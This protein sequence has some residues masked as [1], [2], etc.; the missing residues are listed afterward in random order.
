MNIIQ[1]I[2]RNGT[3]LVEMVSKMLDTKKNI[4]MTTTNNLT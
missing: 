2:I 1:I 3:I 4:Y